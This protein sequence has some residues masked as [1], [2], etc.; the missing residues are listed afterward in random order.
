MTTNFDI[1]NIINK[2]SGKDRAIIFF[3]ELLNMSICNKG[4]FSD[5]EM[6]SLSKSF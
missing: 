3:D 4:K 5:A 2:A 6:E 1:Y